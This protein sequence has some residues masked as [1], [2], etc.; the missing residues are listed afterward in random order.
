MKLILTRHGETEENKEG[1]LQGWKSGIL[2]ETGRQQAALLGERLKKTKIDVIYTSDLGRCVKTAREIAEYHPKVKFIKD[3]RLRERKLGIFESKRVGKNDWDALEGDIFTNRPKGGENFIEVW[4]RLKDFY[5]EILKKYRNE[6]VL[7]VGHGGSMRLL[8]GLIYK[9][10]LEY[11]LLKIEKLK[12]TAITELE[13][14]SDG[15]YKILLLN[16]EK[17]LNS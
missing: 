15:S 14:N 5:E 1:I 16:S 8:Q 7:V 13:L 6:T 10:D 9:K 2:S 12:N 3:K 11:S 17:H 4:A